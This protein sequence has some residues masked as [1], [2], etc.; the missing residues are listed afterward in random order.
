MSPKK[1]TAKLFASSSFRRLL[2]SPSFAPV[3]FIPPR[4]MD[5]IRLQSLSRR[6]STDDTH[7]DVSQTDILDPTIRPEII[8][9]WTLH[10]GEKA[11]A[12]KPSEAQVFLSLALLCTH[13][14]SLSQIA[15]SITNRE[16]DLEAQCFLGSLRCNVD[17]GSIFI[18]CYTLGL[19]LEK[20]NSGDVHSHSHH[21]SFRYRSV[22]IFSLFPCILMMYSLYL[23]LYRSVSAS[24]VAENLVVS[25]Q[26]PTVFSMVFSNGIAKASLASAEDR[27]CRKIHRNLF[28]FQKD[29]K[30]QCGLSSWAR[31]SQRY[32]W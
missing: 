7:T 28:F 26:G 23:F 10:P 1:E 30:V 16:T 25:V 12:S 3:E 15:A 14:L 32:I 22:L 21:H 6:G 4:F 8:Q 13:I 29:S 17:A 2:R 27:L 31:S 18:L 19:V 24:V 20:I 11:S 9:N 5:E